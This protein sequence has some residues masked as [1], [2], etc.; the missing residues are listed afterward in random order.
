MGL[1]VCSSKLCNFISNIPNSCNKGKRLVL[2]SFLQNCFWVVCLFTE[3]AMGSGIS[4]RMDFLGSFLYRG[5][6]SASIAVVSLLL[7]PSYIT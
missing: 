4:K 3:V 5:P 2:Y 6:T 1:L 7:V